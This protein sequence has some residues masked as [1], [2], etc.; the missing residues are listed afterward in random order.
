MN[1]KTFIVG[2]ASDIGNLK[3]LNED[4]ILVKV[5]KDNK[6]LYGLFIVADGMGGLSYG[7]KVSEL[8]ITE[9]KN[10]WDTELVH[11]MKE[12]KRKLLK[13]INTAIKTKMYVINQMI[14]DYSINFNK[15]LGTTLSILFI[16]KDKYSISHIGDSRIYKFNRKL[17]KL[18]NDHTWVAEQVRQ[19]NLSVIEAKNHLRSHVLLQ[20]LGLNEEIKIYNKTGKV[21]KDDIFVLC[22]DGIYNYLAEEVFIDNLKVL[23][24]NYN[25]IQN[26]ANNIISKV[27]EGK[28][29]DNASI[30]IVKQIKCKLK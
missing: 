21:K 11:M 6:E 15:K 30:I 17:S 10:W 9:L 5:A 22:S 16:Y 27:K 12:N 8:A 25:D 23:N 4:K 24:K 29:K 20:C 26:V 7:E 1:T 2:E 18:T 3:T 19:G 14:L 28:A 13:D